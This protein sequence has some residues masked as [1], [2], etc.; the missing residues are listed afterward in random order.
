M[1]LVQSILR[2]F[3]DDMGTYHV[4]LLEI[5][6]YMKSLFLMLFVA[7]SLCSFKPLPVVK[8]TNVGHVKDAPKGTIKIIVSGGGG[9]YVY[10][11]L[12]RPGDSQWVEQKQC[13]ENNTATFSVYVGEEWVGGAVSS[14]GVVVYG[15]T[16]TVE[17]EGQQKQIACTFDF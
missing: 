13:D 6:N 17:Y 7:L 10:A 1:N 16:A 8:A 15:G 5:H 9:G 2:V 3:L 11:R 14:Q 4:L 12:Y